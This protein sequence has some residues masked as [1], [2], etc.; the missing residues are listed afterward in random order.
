M[1]G[2]ESMKGGIFLDRES[3]AKR[4]REISDTYGLDVDPDSSD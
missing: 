4:I 1:L 2:M 3:A